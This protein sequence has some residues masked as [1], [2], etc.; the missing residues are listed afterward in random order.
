MEKAIP[1]SCRRNEKKT[2]SVW[3]YRLS[4]SVHYLVTVYACVCGLFDSDAFLCPINPAVKH[5]HFSVHSRFQMAFKQ[6][7]ALES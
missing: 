4:I 1:R 7:Q 6:T 5:K 3:L 2:V